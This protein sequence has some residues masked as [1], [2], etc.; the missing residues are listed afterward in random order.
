MDDLDNLFDMAHQDALDMI[1]IEE[2]KFLIAQCEK[3]RRGAISGVDLVLTKKEVR[4][5]K[6][7]FYE[8]KRKLQSK[9]DE[10]KPKTVILAIKL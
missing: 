8:E 7:E 3:G 2:V 4:A 5:Q 1:T 6:R 9:E 10:E